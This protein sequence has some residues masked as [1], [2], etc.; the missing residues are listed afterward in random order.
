MAHYAGPANELP[1][2]ISELFED[3]EYWSEP[4]D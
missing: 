3:P 2:F 1:G 4:G